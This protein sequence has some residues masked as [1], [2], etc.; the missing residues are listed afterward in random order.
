MKYTGNNKPI[1][2][3]MTNSTCYNGTRVFTPQGVLWHSTGANNPNLR[4][5]VQP[6]ENDSNYNELIRLLGKNNN[7]NDWN[8][9]YVEAGLNAWIG[10]LAD[11][12]VA[13]VQTMPLNY[14]PWGCGSGS[15][16]SCNNTHVQFE[17]LEDSLNDKSYFDKVYK[18]A[19]EFTAYICKMYNLDPHGYITVNGVKCPVITC[20]A[21]SA[22]LGLGSNH[23]DILHWFKKYGKTMDDVRNDVAKLMGKVDVPSV[24]T[25]QPST[26][27]SFAVGDEVKLV[28]GATYTSGKK[29][30]TWVFNAKLYVRQVNGDN[31]IISTLKTGA[32]TGIVNKKY[33]TAYGKINPYKVKVTASALNIRSGPGIN[34]KIVGCIKD[35]GVYTIIDEKNGFGFLKSEAGWISLQ[36]TRKI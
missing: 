36:Y 6:S 19:C 3:M 24:T 28:S 14:R 29:I 34:Y 5:Y 1:Q 20:H 18:E 9:Q 13:T 30:P 7:R 32:I 35:E 23:A 22:K 17:V 8:H 4:R 15:K 27:S 12:T 10:K 26:S 33:L 21:E 11:G 16:G 31:V 25:Q 2:C